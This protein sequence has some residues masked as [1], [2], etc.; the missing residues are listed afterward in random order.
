[1]PNLLHKHRK[2]AAVIVGLVALTFLAA[3]LVFD[4]VDNKP[5][6]ESTLHGQ[7]VFVGNQRIL[8]D[9]QS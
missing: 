9:E 2:T 4:N 8:V 1:M 6:G 5:W 3:P 7:T